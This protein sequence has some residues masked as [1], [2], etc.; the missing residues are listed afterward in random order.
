MNISPRKIER[1][2]EQAFKG[3]SSLTRVV[4]ADRVHAFARRNMTDSVAAAYALGRLDAMTYMQEYCME[5]LNGIESSSKVRS[6]V[7][8]M[9]DLTSEEFMRVL[10]KVSGDR[11]GSH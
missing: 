10:G 8:A 9:R 3:D 2:F 11:L 5:A 1:L 7:D 6:A 4:D